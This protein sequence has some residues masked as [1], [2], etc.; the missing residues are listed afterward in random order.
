MFIY[1][2]NEHSLLLL[3]NLP[4]YSKVPL[5]LF[6]QLF[7]FTSSLNPHFS[8]KTPIYPKNHNFS[9]KASTSL[10]NLHFFSKPPLLL[11]N[12]HFSTQPPLL[13]STFTF[14]Q[15][16]PILPKTSNS[17]QNLK[18]SPK[19]TFLSKTFTFLKTSKESLNLYD[20]PILL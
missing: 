13:H 9:S 19:P 14:P 16:L 15:N 20:L 2:V 11:I 18:F 12:L 8:S 6:Y 3:G 7:S 10:L 1:P 5:L 4:F 17:P